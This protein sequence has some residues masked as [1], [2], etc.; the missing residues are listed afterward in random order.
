MILRVRPSRVSG[1]IAVPGSKSHT[2]RG[3]AAAL[4]AAG[5][6]RLRRPLVSD[7]TLS[8]LHAAEQLGLRC[9]EAAGD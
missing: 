5:T 1:S 7:D 8:V 6:C 2:I 4:S 3:L 9:E